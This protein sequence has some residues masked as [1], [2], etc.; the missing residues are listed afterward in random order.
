MKTQIVLHTTNSL[1]GK[2]AFKIERSGQLIQNFD[3]SLSEISIH[4]MGGFNKPLTESQSI[5]IEFAN[6]GPVHFQTLTGYKKTQWAKAFSHDVNKGTIF[7]KPSAANDFR[8]TIQDPWRGWQH[9]EKL[10]LAQENTALNLIEVLCAEHKIPLQLLPEKIRFHACP[11]AC[12]KFKG[13][14]LH[15]N[16]RSRSLALSPR[17]VDKLYRLIDAYSLTVCNDRVQ[18]S[19]MAAPPHGML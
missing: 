5:G 15:G 11:E 7:L 4:P 18:A 14:L 2:V 13:I 6:C 9:Y 3:S 17:Q 1:R 8:P 12:L 16:W 10:T 19:S